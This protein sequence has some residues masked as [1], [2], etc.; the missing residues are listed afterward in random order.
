MH[1]IGVGIGIHKQTVLILGSIVQCENTALTFFHTLLSVLFEASSE[2]V[3]NHGAVMSAFPEKQKVQHISQSAIIFI[4]NSLS[5][6]LV[7]HMMT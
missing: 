3:N 6:F 2:S 7:S 4:R 5:Y 1:F